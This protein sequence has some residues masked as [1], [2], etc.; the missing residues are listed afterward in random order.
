MFTALTI[1]SEWI[2]KVS[3]KLGSLNDQILVYFSRRVRM[4]TLNVNTLQRATPE[5]TGTK[6]SDHHSMQIESLTKKRASFEA[7]ISKI[8]SSDHKEMFL[9]A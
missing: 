3:F 6:A 9:K 5:T 2:E 1:S 4:I 7:V 8:E